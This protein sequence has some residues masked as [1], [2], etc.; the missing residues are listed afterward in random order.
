MRPSTL[1]AFAVLV[2]ALA[3][4]G[5]P[6]ARAQDKP[7]AAAAPGLDALMARFRAIPGL[8]ARFREEKRIA[9]LAKPLVSEGTIH[10]APP[11]RLA[12]HQLTPTISSVL[13]EGN[14]LR[15]GD[16]TSEERV[17]LGAS[18]V[19]RA[20]VDGFLQLLAGDRASLE[21][22]FAIEH[23][24]GGGDRWE[25]VLRPKLPAIARIIKEM[26]FA[27]EGVVVARMRLL[28]ATGDEAITTFSE[29]D[30]RRRYT[31][32]EAQQVFRLPKK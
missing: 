26:A 20:F 5:A 7:P 15:F 31:P 32:A 28:E 1:L 23:R 8:S 13:L 24:P 3:P 29:V 19:V 18:P 11:G 30:P 22:A 6:V 14:T 27:G 2:A 9:L 4:A 17:D 21:K 10:Y 25:I 12:R 16:G